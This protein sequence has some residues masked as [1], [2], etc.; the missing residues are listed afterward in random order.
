MTPLSRDNPAIGA[1]DLKKAEA[2]P[3][4]PQG[5][6]IGFSRGRKREKNKKLT[7]N[8]SIIDAGASNCKPLKR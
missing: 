7:K 8:K 5:L 4:P 1:E 3:S 2:I 6:R